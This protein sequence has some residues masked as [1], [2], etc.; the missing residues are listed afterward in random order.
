MEPTAEA[1]S[2]DKQFFVFRGI[3]HAGAGRIR[4]QLLDVHRDYV[5]RDAA[6]RMLHGGPLYDLQ[7]QTIGSC[8]ILE[9]GAKAE[10]DAWLA[11]E[12]FFSAGLFAIVSVERWGWSY[13][14]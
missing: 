11:S 10:V 4:A 12:P 9:A 3:D 6:V 2:L 13:G 5:R 8:L 14:R 1:N 7:E